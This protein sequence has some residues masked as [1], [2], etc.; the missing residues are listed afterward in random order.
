MPLSKSG[1]PRVNGAKSPDPKSVQCKTGSAQ[2][3]IDQGRCAAQSVVLQNEELEAS[4][5]LVA[6]FLRRIRPKDVV[7][8]NLTFELASIEWCL[9]RIRDIGTRLLD[10]ER[11]GQEPALEAA[12]IERGELSRL[13]L[14][15]HS[16]VD[17]SRFLGVLNL[18]KSQLIRARQSVLGYLR[19]L[20]KLFPL[21]DSG[22]EV[23]P[24]HPFGVKPPVPIEP[25]SNPDS[26]AIRAGDCSTADQLA[27]AKPSVPVT[28]GGEGGWCPLCRRCKS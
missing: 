11:I 8:Y 10:N 19:D 3:A 2:D 27:H 5:E 4:E 22:R 15:G 25:E 12:G 9:T 14:A 26:G 6:Y 21:P 7:E 24:R 16:F 13:I 28:G 20:R 23:L 1:H 17:R 18:R